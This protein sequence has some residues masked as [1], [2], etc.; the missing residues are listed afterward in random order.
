VPQAV[1][2]PGYVALELTA[3][4]AVKRAQLC[5]QR[6]WCPGG[7]PSSAFDPARSEALPATEP[8]I[9]LCRD[10]K[11]TMGLG[12]VAVE[13]CSESTRRP[14][15]AVLPVNMT[16]SDAC[17]SLCQTHASLPVTFLLVCTLWHLEM[18]R[19]S[20]ASISVLLLHTNLSQECFPGICC[21]CTNMLDCTLPAPA[22]TAS[23]PA[24]CSVTPPG[25]YTASGTTQQCAAGSFRANWT[26][27]AAA[28]A[29]CQA[30][31]QG[32]RADKTDR[33]ATYSLAN[34]TQSF[35]AVAT[36]A[37]SCCEWGSSQISV[38]CDL[39]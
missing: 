11:W 19:T 33:L 39:H 4:G 31:G 1:L 16:S 24:L 32:V 26:T 15:A 7:S 20:V 2:L 3:A 28:A 35:V 29:A 34:S 22:S 10:G 30:C 36:T 13:G 27:D 37:G 6:Y 21:D 14:V 25:F 17:W 18:Y 23:V 12:A 5:P 38:T 9:K 8:T